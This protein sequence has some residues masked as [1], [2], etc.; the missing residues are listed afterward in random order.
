MT[1]NLPPSLPEIQKLLSRLLRAPRGVLAAL[2]EANAEEREL[3]RRWIAGS[4]RLSAVERLEIYANQY[5]YRLHDALADDFPTVRRV[6]GPAH[7][8]NLLTDYLLACPS[9]HF[10]LRYAGR[11]L[12]DFLQS[13]PLAQRWPYLPDLARLEW[14]VLEAFDAPD[15][16]TCTSEA[17]G[18][19]PAELW[20]E[21]VLHWIPALFYLDSA[22]PVHELWRAQ[23]KDDGPLPEIQEAPTRLRVWRQNERVFVAVVNEQEAAYL[24]RREPLAMLCEELARQVGEAEAAQRMAMWLHRWIEDG[25][26]RSVQIQTTGGAGSVENESPGCKGPQ[27]VTRTRGDTT[28]T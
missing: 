15:A 28:V 3:C 6:T 18:Q 10:S 7:F 14:L 19:V 5:F 16:D 20:G 21:L 13:H 11:H 9:R 22:W 1:M 17:L 25:L 4:S 23:L 12:A 8:H 24:G 2:P 27:A 26:I